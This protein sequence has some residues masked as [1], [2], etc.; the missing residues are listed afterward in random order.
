MAA[1]EATTN[2]VQ[3][4]ARFDQST[5]STIFIFLFYSSREKKSILGRRA[6]H[7]LLGCSSHTVSQSEAV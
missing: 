5:I 1:A 3:R 7:R 6:Y 4:R 2:R